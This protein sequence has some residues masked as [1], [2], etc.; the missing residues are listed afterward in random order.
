MRLG[1]QTLCRHHRKIGCVKGGDIV[2]HRGVE[3][4]HKCHSVRT[5]WYQMVTAPL[6]RRT[7]P[8]LHLHLLFLG[9][10]GVVVIA[11]G[12]GV[13]E[14]LEGEG[15]SR[16]VVIGEGESYTLPSAHQHGTSQP[17]GLAGKPLAGFRATPDRRIIVL[18]GMI[19]SLIRF[20][21]PLLH[22]Q[23]SLRKRQLGENRGF[24]PSF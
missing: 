15:Q 19:V 4:Q 14:L 6:Q 8:P 17:R 5:P 16:L 7:E 24:R 22:R 13:G 23:S 12:H 11:L 20:K 10:L 3:G 2:Y 21:N 18:C 1:Q 9:V